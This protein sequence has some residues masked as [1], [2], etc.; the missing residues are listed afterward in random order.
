MNVN[1]CFLL[2]GVHLIFLPDQIHPTLQQHQA[3]AN[4]L[5]KG[6]QLYIVL[7]LVF[8]YAFVINYRLEQKLF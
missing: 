8:L 3:L 5:N 2:G 6:L 1:L 4:Y 7:F